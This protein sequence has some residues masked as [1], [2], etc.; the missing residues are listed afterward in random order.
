MRKNFLKNGALKNGTFIFLKEI[1]AHQTPV[2]MEVNAW[3]NR[4]V[5]A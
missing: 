1:L 5:A 2:K 4:Q 3:F